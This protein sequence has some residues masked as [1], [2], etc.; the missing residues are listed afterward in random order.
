ML[1]GC[2]K[3]IDVL[4]AD[5]M[6]QGEIGILLHR[7]YDSILI[8]VDTICKTSPIAKRCG[9]RC[10]F[11]CTHISRLVQGGMYFVNTFRRGPHYGDSALHF[12][13]LL[14]SPTVSVSFWARRQHHERWQVCPD[15]LYSYQ[16]TFNIHCCCDEPVPLLFWLQRLTCKRWNL[17][18]MTTAWW[19][20]S[21]QRISHH[22]L[23]PMSILTRF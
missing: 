13:V 10:W 5:E 15:S 14:L 20:C 4:L 23:V 8:V 1:P 2:L 18:A 9:C 3:M 6:C 22:W 17:D 19:S 16:S 7:V 12:R 11:V 21:E